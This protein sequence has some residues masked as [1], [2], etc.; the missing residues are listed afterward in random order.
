MNRE[1]NLQEF[2]VSLTVGGLA[3]VLLCLVLPGIENKF[4]VLA[5]MPIFWF[6]LTIAVWT[7]LDIY[8]RYREE[9]Q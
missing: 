1:K 5:L 7:G 3:S 4:D 8:D 6:M 2:S 9:K